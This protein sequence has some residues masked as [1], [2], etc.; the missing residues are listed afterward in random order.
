V[1]AALA[2]RGQCTGLQW[3]AYRD[4]DSWVLILRW[5]AG[6]SDNRAHWAIQP[7]PR[8]NTL[9]PKDDAAREILDPTP[10]T[11][12]EIHETKTATLATDQ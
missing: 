11:L 12:R 6:R 3:D 2:E 10:R 7:G 8:T 4:D 1:T 9:R 5:Q